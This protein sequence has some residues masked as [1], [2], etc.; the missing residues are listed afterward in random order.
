MGC[1]KHPL[2]LL[3]Y[4]TQKVTYHVVF[5]PT[6]FLFLFLAVCDDIEQKTFH[7]IVQILKRVKSDIIVTDGC[8]RCFQQQWRV[9]EMTT[10]STVCRRTAWRLLEMAKFSTVCRR[11]AW[12]LARRPCLSRRFRAVPELILLSP[13]LV[14]AVTVAGW[15]LLRGCVTVMYRSCCRVVTWGCPLWSRSETVPDV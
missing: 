15:N 14:P 12:R 1:Q 4:S 5:I 9:L 10:F 8:L 7:S 3:L 11:T 2:W 6:L 13:G